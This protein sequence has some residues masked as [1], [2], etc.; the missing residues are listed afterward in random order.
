MGLE[1][2]VLARDE[3]V[4]VVLHERGALGVRVVGGHDLH[5]AHHA[6]GLP[7]A[8]G[9]E[10]EALLHEALDGEGRELL[11]GA[12]V[13]EVVGEG[14]VVVLH[15]EA[16]D[17]DLLGSLDLD[18]TTELLRVAAVE[19]EAVGL[20]VLVG[21]LLD[22]GGGH[23]LDVRG[24]VVDR[25]RIDGPAE[26]DLGL[27]LVAIGDGDVAHG[28]GEAGDADVAGLVDTHGDAL[29]LAELGEGD[30]ILP[31][32][33]DDLV[34]P[35]HAGKDVPELALTVGGLVLVHEVHVDGVVRDLLVVLRRKLAQRLAEV[36][37]AQDVV[38]RGAEGVGPGDDAGAVG[39]VVGLVEDLLD[40]RSG[41]EVGL[42]LDLERDLLR[43]VEV[44]DDLLGV[45]VHVLEALVAVQVLG[46]GAEIELVL[47]DL[48]HVRS[49]RTHMRC[50]RFWAAR[51][52]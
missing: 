24:E 29:P 30:G 21:E 27:D 28:V 34:V 2:A 39:V 33:K 46:A 42:E 12:E 26:L 41:E 13:T 51:P 10:A 11:Q 6:R 40:H 19:H 50:K 16:L 43:G 52:P 15:E 22:L 47:L 36:L 4:G 35:A 14:V 32:T 31:V 18:V 37:Q 48:E 38:L 7:V 9:A 49:F 45:L 17:A 25:P 44:V 5:E 20:V 23:G 3:V 8:L 1:D